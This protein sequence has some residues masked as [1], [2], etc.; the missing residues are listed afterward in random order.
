MVRQRQIFPGGQRRRVVGVVADALVLNCLVANAAARLFGGGI[1]QFF[2]RRAVRLVRGIRQTQLPAGAGLV[3]HTV[4]QL[5]QKRFRRVVQGHADGNHRPGRA[6]RALLALGFQHLLFWQ[7]AGLFA[8]K[9]PLDK[10]GGPV[11]HRT[12]ALFLQH[13]K[14]VAHQLFDAFQFQIQWG[15]LFSD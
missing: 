6:L 9:A 1:H 11:Q 5:A 15:F 2:H 7:V 13:L 10:S 14:G 8:E 4:Q 3:Q 12:R